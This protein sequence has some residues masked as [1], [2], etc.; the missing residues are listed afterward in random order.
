MNTTK[1]T[2]I[3]INNFKNFIGKKVEVE[4]CCYF[5]WYDVS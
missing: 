2:S 3:D 4:I 1:V 5:R